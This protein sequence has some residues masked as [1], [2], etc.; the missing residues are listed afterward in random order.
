MKKFMFVT[1]TMIL[2]LS[3]LGIQASPAYALGAT[4][5][6]LVATLSGPAIDGVVPSGKA[7]FASFQG[8]NSL[9]VVMSNLNLAD[10]TCLNAALGRTVFA[11]IL[12]RSGSAFLSLDASL[13]PEVRPGE[14]ITISVGT[15]GCGI[16]PLAPATGTVILSGTFQ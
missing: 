6:V 8:A 9:F 14:V 13:T 1:V 2:I 11:G 5:R 3:A 7:E 10:G 4:D 12:V 16:I 15:P